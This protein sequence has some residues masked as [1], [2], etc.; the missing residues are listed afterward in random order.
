MIR[1]RYDSTAGIECRECS[2]VNNSGI[3]LRILEKVYHEDVYEI[4][5]IKSTNHYCWC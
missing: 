3:Y 5:I 4:I 1:V 2:R